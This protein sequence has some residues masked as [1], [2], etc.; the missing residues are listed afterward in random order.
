[1]ASTVAKSG[2]PAANSPVRSA[3]EADFPA[4]KTDIDGQPRLGRYD[5]GCD[6][7]SDAPVTNR[8]LSPRDVGPSWLDRHITHTDA[9]R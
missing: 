1:V 2:N 6:Q 3:A 4:I 7:F 5:V 9:R 8:A